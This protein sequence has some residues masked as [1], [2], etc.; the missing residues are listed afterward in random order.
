MMDDKDGVDSYIGKFKKYW[1][2]LGLEFPDTY[3]KVLA[4]YWKEERG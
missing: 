3:K 4:S 2:F 1:N